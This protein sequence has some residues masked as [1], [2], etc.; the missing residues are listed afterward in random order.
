METCHDLGERIFDCV[1]VGRDGLDL[2]E[3]RIG[4]HNH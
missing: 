2:K 1:D 3:W 4:Y